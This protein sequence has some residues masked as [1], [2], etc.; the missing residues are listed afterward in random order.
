MIFAD[1]NVLIDVTEADPLW[2]AWSQRQLNAARASDEVAINDVVYAE[3][4]VA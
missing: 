1:T 4:S 2:A 3:L